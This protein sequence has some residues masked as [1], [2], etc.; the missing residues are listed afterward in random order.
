MDP[1]RQGGTKLNRQG[2]SAASLSWPQKDCVLLGRPTSTAPHGG[3]P[4]TVG[5]LTLADTCVR[6]MTG[7]WCCRQEEVK[8][9]MVTSDDDLTTDIT[10]EG[11]EEELDRFR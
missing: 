6:V 1:V 11:D 2:L 3:P 9:K 4:F 7:V 10:L 5:D 8:V